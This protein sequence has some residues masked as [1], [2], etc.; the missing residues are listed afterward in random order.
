[1]GDE[2]DW[3]GHK[4]R[5]RRVRYL[6]KHTSSR[7]RWPCVMAEARASFMSGDTRVCRG[8]VHRLREA[9]DAEARGHNASFAEVTH[10]GHFQALRLWNR[11]K[12]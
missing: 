6:A 7:W 12:G 10:S 5:A 3:A 4:H 1:M 2:E 11:T 8:T 9:G